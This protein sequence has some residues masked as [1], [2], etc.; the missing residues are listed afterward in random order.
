MNPQIEMSL[1][2]LATFLS[3]IIMGISF[4]RFKKWRQKK[5]D[6]ENEHFNLA[7]PCGHLCGVEIKFSESAMMTVMQLSK[8]QL[9]DFYFDEKSARLLIRELKKIK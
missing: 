5:N 6:E 9:I 1:S 8:D 2:I 3:G 4:V 7:C